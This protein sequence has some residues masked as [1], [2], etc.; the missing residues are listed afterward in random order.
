MPA[1]STTPPKE[2]LRPPLHSLASVISMFVTSTAES[3]PVIEIEDESEDDFG[4]LDAE[5]KAR[6]D[7]YQDRTRME[8][9]SRRVTRSQSRRI[10][11]HNFA[12]LRRRRASLA[13][14]P[15]KSQHPVNSNAKPNLLSLSPPKKS[16]ALYGIDIPPNTQTNSLDNQQHRLENQEGPKLKT[17]GKPA[18]SSYFPRM[19]QTRQTRIHRQTTSQADLPD[20]SDVSL[21]EDEDRTALLDMRGVYTHLPY[22][23]DQTE[24]ALINRIVRDVNTAWEEELESAFHKFASDILPE[25]MKSNADILTE[26]FRRSLYST[27]G[28][29]ILLNIDANLEALT[30]TGIHGKQFAAAA[31]LLLFAPC[32]EASC[33]RLFSLIKFISGKRRYNLKLSSLNGCIMLAQEREIEALY[34]QTFSDRK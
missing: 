25:V 4:R 15:E 21:T 30:H 33:E 16:T 9:T 22:T 27:R 18:L 19:P 24:F 28:E 29:K 31:R 2:T 7:E 1:Q 32:S 10:E 23:N 13:G 12:L 14:K 17:P 11:T 3:H 26:Q 6:N 5:Q 34:A 8:P 20:L